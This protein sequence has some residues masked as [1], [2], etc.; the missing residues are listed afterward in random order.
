MS[1]EY[2]VI[3]TS[4]GAYDASIQV[5]KYVN[6]ELN[7][8]INMPYASYANVWR[9]FDGLFKIMY[10]GPS[11]GY[12]WVLCIITGIEDHTD[13]EQ[14]QWRFD[15]LIDLTLLAVQTNKLLYLLKDKDCVVYTIS[16][17]VLKEVE[18]VVNI[19]TQSFIDFGT[20]DKPTSDMLLALDNPTVL[21]WNADEI[22][23]LSVTVTATPFEQSVV[24]DE[25]D[26][27]N[28]T[29]TGIE[30][31]TVECTGTPFFSLS[32][33]SGTTWKMHDGTSWVILTS[34][35]SGMQAETLE[36]ITPEQWK[37]EIVGITSMLLR[38]VLAKVEDT[39]NSLVIDFTN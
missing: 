36:A 23:S 19:T 9:E 7:E 20:T 5:E 27:S 38:F 39:V 6:S 2:K 33:D 26:L 29:I 15:A 18:G 17:N 1:V 32:F 12:C 21:A 3:T 34:N 28:S 16:D 30:R 10:G 31:V 24:T 37:E 13:G 14:M 25:I 8:T 22:A 35:G 11:T 4:T